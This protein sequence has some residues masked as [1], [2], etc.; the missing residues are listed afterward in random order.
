MKRQC[1]TM[2]L[3]P[4][5]EEASAQVAR[6]PGRRVAG[7]AYWTKVD[8]TEAPAVTREAEEDPGP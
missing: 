4:A 5:H 1:P 7:T 6:A 2:A 3:L 8:T